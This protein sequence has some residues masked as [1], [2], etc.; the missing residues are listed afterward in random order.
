[1]SKRHRK[2]AQ[3]MKSAASSTFDL[4]ALRRLLAE[5]PAA[6]KDPFVHA[7]ELPKVPQPPGAA[8]AV[9]VGMAM[10]DANGGSFPYSGYLG[11]QS[12]AGQLEFGLYFPGYPYL[13]QLAQRTEYRQP[14]ETLA[15]EMTRKWIVMKS[16]GESDKTDKISELEE[17][18]KRLNIQPLFRKVT[19][20]DGY[21]GLGMIF[22]KLKGD[23]YSAIRQSPLVIDERSIGK[24]DLE[25]F[26]TIEPMWITPLVWNSID[27]TVPTFYNPEQW[28][29]LGRETHAT[30]MLKFISR[31][32][33]DIIKP[34]YN[35]G[36]ISLTQLIDPYVSR[37][38]KTV[39]SVNRLINNFSIIV[40]ASD[41]GSV[42]SSGDTD[43]YQSVLTRL[44][45]FSKHRDNQGVFLLD[46]ATEALEQISV[47]LTSLS[48]LQAQALE[49]MAYPT[50]EP[51]VILTG[52]TPSGLNASSEGEI[53]VWHNWVH[54]MQEQLYRPN[55]ERVFRI[56]QLN[57]W[58][59]IDPEITFDFEPLKEITGDQ[60]AAVQKTKTDSVVALHA[61]GIIDEEESREF[62][63]NDPDSGFNNLDVNKEINP[64]EI[65]RED[66]PQGERE[67]IRISA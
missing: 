23:E 67:E 22:I 43:K 54:A 57:L 17:E 15:K 38:L 5:S 44:S 10:D 58:G 40:L 46:K 45:L 51:L 49:H 61:E 65:E 60:V 63:A 12:V 25:G 13:A 9:R 52:I 48:E 66:D 36:G 20:H 6:P 19:E 14:V 35:F 56:V 11:A 16:T 32:V 37:W 53:E 26:T 47:S 33:P 2:P 59:K 30:R 50:H 24:G 39:D 1:M 29:V 28:M 3:A 27:P 31:E 64:Q 18:M 34:A 7:L 42:L 62:L 41:L 55:L 21:Y 8:K 4:G